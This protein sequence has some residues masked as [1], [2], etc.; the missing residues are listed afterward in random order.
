MQYTMYLYTVSVESHVLISNTVLPN[1]FLRLVNAKYN[2]NRD[3][4]V[5]AE[6]IASKF[7]MEYAIRDLNVELSI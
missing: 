7:N 6:F 5:N 3:T 4:V 2:A 1:I